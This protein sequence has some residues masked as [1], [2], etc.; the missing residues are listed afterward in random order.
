MIRLAFGIAVI[1]VLYALFHGGISVEIN[2][3]EYQAQ[4]KTEKEHR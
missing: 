1:V 3:K 2:G 4:I